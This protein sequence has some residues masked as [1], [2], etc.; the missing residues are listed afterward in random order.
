MAPSP[1]WECRRGWLGAHCVA[2]AKLREML[3]AGT[4]ALPPNERLFEEL[5]AVNWSPTPADDKVMIEPKKTLKSKL[6]RSPD[7]GD[8]VIMAFSDASTSGRGFTIG[9]YSV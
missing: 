2:S 9:T 6:G 7:V 8:A 3:E 1:P 4:I 5:L